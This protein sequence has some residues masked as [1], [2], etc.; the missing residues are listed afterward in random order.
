MKKL[1]ISLTFI[2]LIGLAGVISNVRAGEPGIEGAT[3]NGDTNCD[4]TRDMSDAIT[5]LN[6]LFVGGRRPCPLAE[7]VGLT[8]QVADLESSLAE[9]NQRVLD[10]EAE[11]ERTTLELGDRLADANRSLAVLRLEVE[12]LQAQA[13]DCCEQGPDID[14]D[15]L[16]VEG[17]TRLEQNEQGYWEYIHDQ[18]GIVLVLLPGGSFN[19]GSPVNEEGRSS[20]E[21]PVHEVRLSPFLIGKYE[22]TQAQWE[23]IFPRGPEGSWSF[24][25]PQTHDWFSNRGL[26]SPRPVIL[27]PA[28]QALRP[29]ENINWVTIQGFEERTGLTLPSEAQWEY[30]ARAGA[31]TKWNFGNDEGSLAGYAWFETGQRS[32]T[33]P[34]GRLL[35]NQFGIH[36]MYGNVSEWCEDIYL[37][38]F[39]SNPE[40]CLRDP[41]AGGDDAEGQRVIRGGDYRDVLE[42][43]SS[44]FSRLRSAARESLLESLD[45][46]RCPGQ[47]GF[48]LVF[49]LSTE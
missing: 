8:E 13:G 10:L 25:H 21:G 19:M 22:V 49:N 28:Q 1:R 47:P 33:S 26:P 43:P 34:V 48:R 17:F 11:L 42:I 40:D 27:P 35:P 36:D 6:W 23:L 38:D 9:R 46:C 39:Y 20:D 29:V 31:E 24:N 37:P 41:V 32:S 15:N 2:S 3:L 30:A 12:T 16:Q 45:L 4:G 14:I 44:D 5:L 7:P 18:T